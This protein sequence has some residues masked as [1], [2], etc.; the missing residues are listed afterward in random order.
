M[1]QVVDRLNE[2]YKTNTTEYNKQVNFVKSLGFRI[3]RNSNNEHKITYNVEDILRVQGLPST[4]KTR[5][6][7]EAFAYGFLL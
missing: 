3:Y 5:K 6:N 1:G 2:L 7:V 4:E